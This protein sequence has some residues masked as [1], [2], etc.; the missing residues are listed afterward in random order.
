MAKYYEGKCINCGTTSL[1]ESED[2]IFSEL[3]GYLEQFKKYYCFCPH[4]EMRVL[5][6]EKEGTICD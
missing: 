1:F 4:C 5:L 6:E 2:E 3:G